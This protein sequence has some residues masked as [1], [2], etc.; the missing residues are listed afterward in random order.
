MSRG[1]FP[2]TSAD[3]EQTSV[4]VPPGAVVRDVIHRALSEDIGYGD[5]TSDAIVGERDITAG[6][7]VARAPG[8]VA[9]LPFAAQVFAEVDSRIRF[10]S[11]V[12][13][14]A[15]VA[16]GDVVAA[17]EGPARGI[18]TAERVALNLLQQLSG[19]ATMTREIV[20]LIDGTGARVL[21][22]RKTV[23]GMRALQRYAVRVGGGSN[24]RFNLFD[25][26]LIKE[27][28]ITVAGGISQAVSRAQAAVGPMTRIEV[29]VESLEQ[30]DEALAAGADMILLDNMSAAMLRQAVERAAGRATLE[31]SGDISLET[32]RAVAETGVDYLSSGALTHSARALNLSLLLSAIERPA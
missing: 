12:V 6:A 11:R 3:S 15:R 14:G 29:E 9:G 22:T 31:A 30:L 5:V 26:V 19:V 10:E 23:P 8:V 18:L 13:D 24:H 1:A 17:L 16:V 21:D 7:I 20:D 4:L 32:A 27:N 25:G 2:L 28:H